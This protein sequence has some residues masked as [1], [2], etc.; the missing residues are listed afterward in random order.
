MIPSLIRK[1]YPADLGSVAMLQIR[2]RL[3]R[4]SEQESPDVAMAAVVSQVVVEHAPHNQ[5]VK[6]AGGAGIP[7][8]CIKSNLS[9]LFL[10]YLSLTCA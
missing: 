4:N 3:D 2:L 5:E 7:I 8:C 9:Y 10:L 6:S 1:Q